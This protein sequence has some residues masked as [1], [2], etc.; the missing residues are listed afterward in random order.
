MKSG[1]TTGVRL[2]QLRASPTIVRIRP[3]HQS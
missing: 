3:P 1:R 2:L